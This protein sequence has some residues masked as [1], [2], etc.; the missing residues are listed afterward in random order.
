MNPSAFFITHPRFSGVIAVVMVLLGLIACLVLPVSQYPAI[1]PPQIVVSTV[2]PGASAQIVADMIATPI[3]N[4]LNGLE[5]L[6]YMSSN[7]TDDGTY[8]LTLTFDIGTDANIAQVKVENRLQQVQSLLPDI[9]IQEGLDVVQQ[10]ANI[11]G[12]LVL[13]SPNRTYDALALSQYAYTNIQN[14]LARVPGIGDLTIYS[15]EASMRIWLNPTKLVQYNL[16]ATDVVN[17]IENQNIQASIG[18]LGFAP[19]KGKPAVLSLTAY[20]MLS[21]PQEFQQIILKMDKDGS[22]VTLADV[23]EVELGAE[24]YRINAMYNRAPAV[25]IALSQL[26]NSNALQTMAELKQEISK[27]SQS[28]PEDMELKIAYDSTTFVKASISSIL[29]TLVITFLLVI[30]VVYLFLQNIWATLI[31][32]ITIPVSLIATFMVIYCFGMDINILTLFA[33]ILAIGLVVDDAIIVVERVQYLMKQQK[34][35]ALDASIQAIL[36]IASSVLATT[37]VLL[38]IFIPVGL[39]AGMTGKIYAQFAI[40]ISVAIV[41]SAIN[42]LTL[43]PALCAIFLKHTNNISKFFDLFNRGF[44]WIQKHYLLCVD[45]SCHHLKS[46]VL[47]FIILLGVIIGLFYRTPTSFVPQEDQG[48]LLASVQLPDISSTNETV[49]L[50]SQMSGDILQKQ[51]IEY[52]IGIAGASLLS[53]GGENIGMLVVGLTDWD[54]RTT[55]SLSAN[56]ILEELIQEYRDNHQA[57]IDFFALPAVPGIGTSSGVSFQLNA[58]NQNI[59]P[60]ELE[61][62]T[63]KLT[64]A[65]N[66]NP[67]FVFAY[68]P[69]R[70]DTPHL[71]LDLNRS[72]LQYY[73]IPISNVFTT[74]QNY[75]GSRYVNTFTLA[76]QTNKVIIQADFNARQSIENIEDLYIPSMDG[77]L[78]Q[79]KDFMTVKTVLSPKTIYRFNQYLSAAVS[80]ETAPH[81]SSGSALKEIEKLSQTLGTSFAISW[82]GLSLQEAQTQGLVLILIALAFLFS[83]LFLVALYESWLIAFSVVI[84]NIFA[85][86][87]ALIGVFVMQQSLSIYAQLGLVLL[88]GL[89]SKNAILIVEF[90]VRNCEQGMN[91][92]AAAIKG[93]QERYRAVVMTALTFILGVLPMLL[94]KGAGAASQIS[95]GTTV[96]FGM[97]FATGIGVIFVP[98]LFCVFY[99]LATRKKEPKVRR[100][101]RR[102]K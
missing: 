83:Y 50:L 66:H 89:A 38:A 76:G 25:V 99:R 53:G 92:I 12:F 6:L 72:L 102:R 71:F 9:V 86:L 32:L 95:M 34:M 39:M 81:I 48:I 58:V 98:A 31:P 17:A 5:G 10:S 42:A 23:A 1:T 62:A 21:T 51:G 68:S 59:Q 61:I 90:I 78:V 87:G 63:T 30:L 60:K 100:R 101:Y 44:G 77:Q 2:Y 18:G 85:I 7:S 97:L 45:W 28:F 74:L 19:A 52:V 94:A 55:A 43:S 69:F 35:Q 96:W 40:T 84:T 20:G 93:A 82:T 79:L 24:N 16:T 41:F 67:D 13:E 22:M 73:N 36:D 46:I 65:L 57:V 54:Q 56:A 88:I 70:S 49:E 37:F 80:A 64:N 11:L 27:L 75:L 15:P 47:L 14:P 3:E 33:M 29:S 26:P 91:M 4:K 8:T